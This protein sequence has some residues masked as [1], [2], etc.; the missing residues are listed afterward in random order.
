MA[1]KKRDS[2]TEQNIINAAHKVFLQRGYDGAR[3]QDIADDAQINKAMLH[4]YFDNKDSLFEKV[5]VSAYLQIAPDFNQ[6]I[7]SPKAF[8]E[9]ISDFVNYYSDLLQE[10]PHV[11]GFVVNEMNRNPEMVIKFLKN[12]TTEVAYL[13]LMKVFE[14]ECKK[15]KIGNIHPIH[16]V[17]HLISICYFP[18]S[19]KPMFQYLLRLDE[20]QYQLIIEQRK[21][22]IN[23][24]IIGLFSS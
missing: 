24:F 17:L 8:K 9:R 12:K 19:G 6:I 4:Y 16:F 13:D 2:N 3:M 10:N 20:F 14:K 18:F 1:V 22:E 21:K 11:V 5:F 23:Q 15:L 7:N